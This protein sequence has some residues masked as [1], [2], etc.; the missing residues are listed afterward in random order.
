MTSRIHISP[1]D[2]EGPII[3]IESTGHLQ[4]EKPIILWAK[5]FD[6]DESGT[7]R[8]LLLTML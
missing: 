6:D 4:P 2:T 8:S 3:E 1:K 7:N 5:I